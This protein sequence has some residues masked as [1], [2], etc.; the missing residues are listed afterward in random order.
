[1]TFF[2]LIIIK[3]KEKKS[4]VVR[5]FKTNHKIIVKLSKLARQ[6]NK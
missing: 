3:K 1:L 5:I 2:I 6:S 4:I